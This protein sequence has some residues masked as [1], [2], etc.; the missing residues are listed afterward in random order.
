[1]SD[2]RRGLPPVSHFLTETRSSGFGARRVTHVAR[3]VLADARSRLTA[4]GDAPTREQLASELD[5]RLP[6]R[7]DEILNATGVV[8][9]TNLGRAPWS[10]SAIEAGSRAAGY[11]PVEFDLTGGTRGRRG[12]DAEDRLLAI[13]GAEAALIVNN[14]AAAVL[15]ALRELAKGR[16]VVVSRGELVEIGGGFRVP[17]VLAESG[18]RLVEVGTTNRT[19][20]DDYRARINPET[21][22]VLRVHHSNFRQEGFV[23]SVDLEGLTSLGVPVVVDA[24]SGAIFEISDEPDVKSLLAAGADVVCFSA[25]KLLGGPQA[26]IAVGRRALIER[27]RRQPLM[28]ALR[29]GKVTLAAL[30]ATLDEWLTGAAPPVLRMIEYPVSELKVAVEGWLRQLPQVTA[31]VVEVDGAVGGGSV[32]AR[33]WPSIGLAVNSP[34][35]VRLQQA[36]LRVPEPVLGRIHKGSLLLD[37]RTVVPLGQGERLVASLRAALELLATDSK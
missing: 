34:D 14:G 7:P 30:R 33:T 24:G 31:E 4:D 13:T 2:A 12:G 32:P 20:L 8:L 11:S 21:A 29:P 37:A 19:H 28:R 27:M 18:A 6:P 35:P 23:A 10:E 5:R 15:L 16:E 3:Q 25:D 26:G 17:D 1:M 9:H 36:L 22:A